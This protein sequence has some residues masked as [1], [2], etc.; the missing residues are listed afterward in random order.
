[1]RETGKSIRASLYTLRKPTQSIFRWMHENAQIELRRDKGRIKTKQL[2]DYFQEYRILDKTHNARELWVAHFHYPTLK[3]PRDYPA[4][5]HLKISETY[6]KTLTE[7]QQKTFATVEPI[8][9][10]LRKIDD[11]VLRKLFFDLEP[12]VED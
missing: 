10:V 4:A 11:P 5:A 1:M 7:E 8:D 6:L 3:S 9:G 12:V 2:G